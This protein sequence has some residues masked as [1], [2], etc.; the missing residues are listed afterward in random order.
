MAPLSKLTL[1]KF[2]RSQTH[3]EP[4]LKRRAKALKAPAQ[5]RDILNAALK[6][7]EHTVKSTNIY[8]NITKIFSI[9]LSWCHIR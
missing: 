1:S 7:R 3:Q 9:V 2:E 8:L 5:Q 4:V 6:G